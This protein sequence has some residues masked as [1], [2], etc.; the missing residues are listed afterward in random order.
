MLDISKLRSV[1]DLFP[2]ASGIS[3]CLGDRFLYANNQLF[4]HVRNLF[5][6]E[7]FQFVSDLDERARSYFAAPLVCLQDLLEGGLVPYRNNTSVLSRLVDRS[8]QFRIGPVSLLTQ[9]AHNHVLHESAH[10]ISNRILGRTDGEGPLAKIDVVIRAL[11]CESFANTIESLSIAFAGSSQIHRFFLGLNCYVS[12]T[13]D[14]PRREKVL[15]D[16]IDLFGFRETFELGLVAFLHT[17]THDVTPPEA[18]IASWLRTVFE[19]RELSTAEAVLLD[20][21]VR[22]TFILPQGFR[23]ETS[24][25]FFSILECEKDFENFSEMPLDSAQLAQLGVW[26]RIKSLSGVMANGIKIVS[27]AEA[28]G[29]RRGA[30]AG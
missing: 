11:L 15:R 9:L 13:P 23:Q 30:A 10:L 22:Q 17:N 25:M 2:A 27:P 24:R 7:G 26:E 16:L 20:L 3:E 5:L 21:L 6:S 29:V 28:P 14:L 8:P 1:D 12:Y 19:R 4:R 18:V